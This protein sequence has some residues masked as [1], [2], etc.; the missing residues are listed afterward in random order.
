VD[1]P[2]PKIHE[3][4]FQRI[5]V[6]RDD[7]AP[8][9]LPDRYAVVKAD[10]TVLHGRSNPYEDPTQSQSRCADQERVWNHVWWRRIAYFA[11]VILTFFMIVPPF[12]FGAN[13]G[14]ILP[15]R[16]RAL[17]GFVDLLGQV[18]PGMAQPW[19]EYYRNFPLQLVIGGGIIAGLLI[20][21]SGLQRSI[22]DGMRA[23]WDAIGKAPRTPVTPNAPPKDWV[24]RFRSHPWYRGFFEV[25]TQRVFPF[26]FGFGVLAAVVLIV[27][28]TA[29][30]ASFAAAS[31]IGLTCV[32]VANPPRWDGGPR[33]VSLRSSELCQ[34][35]GLV[36]QAGQ[37]YHVEIAVPKG[38]WFD[39][40]MPVPTAAGLGSGEN[41][42]VF[43][44][45]LPFRRV[46]TTQWFVPMVRIGSRGAEYHPL[47]TGSV[48]FT[49]RVTGQL[50]L[51]VNDAIGIG[52]WLKAF[53][54]NN[55]GTAAVTVKKL[56]AV[57]TP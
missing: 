25:V 34:P 52:P 7:Y 1:V 24:Y 33:T 10:G 29:N 22:S 56:E 28:G 44:P 43:I 51:F 36:L 19:V 53:Y 39:R 12:L 32:D 23:V 6:G 21:S 47:N 9:V 41:P 4:V 16:S 49:P 50:F 27:V 37:P 45:F 20:I 54:G 15:W 35:T 30:R 46:L 2:R 8:I 14:G 31:A 26:V 13:G 48:E 3:S 11:T 40:T 55:H 5:A 57:D 38:Q 42:L 17:S 18:L